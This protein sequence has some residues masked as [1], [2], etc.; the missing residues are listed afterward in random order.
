MATHSSILFWQIPSTEEP[1]RLQSMGSQKLD[2]TEKLH[3]HL[4]CH[5]GATRKKT[6]RRIIKWY[7]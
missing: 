5:F 4:H 7:P 6:F 3:F 1:G 2:T